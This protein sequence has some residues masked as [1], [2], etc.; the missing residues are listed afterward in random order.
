MK[1]MKIDAHDQNRSIIT[2]SFLELGE[3]E[4][5]RGRERVNISKLGVIG[6]GAK[7]MYI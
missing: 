5:D 7:V 2:D 6:M 3:K 4:R 1:P